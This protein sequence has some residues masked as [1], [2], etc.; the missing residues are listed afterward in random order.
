LARADGQAYPSHRWASSV[1]GR[2]QQSPVG[3]LERVLFV[4][5]L[6]LNHRDSLYGTPSVIAKSR[7]REGSTCATQK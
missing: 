2:R 4:V 3:Q 5:S 1:G 7:S 6:P